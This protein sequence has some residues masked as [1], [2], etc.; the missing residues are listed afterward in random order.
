MMTLFN[1]TPGKNE[2]DN[3]NN[4]DATFC[5]TCLHAFEDISGGKG[6]VVYFQQSGTVTLDEISQTATNVSKGSLSGVRLVEY[7]PDYTEGTLFIPGGKC[8]EV[9]DVDW[10]TMQ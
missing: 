1:G 3:E 8:L 10:N 7:D 5:S 9:E 4:S 2:L 6:N